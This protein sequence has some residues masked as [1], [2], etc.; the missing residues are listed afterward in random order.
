MLRVQFD[1]VSPTVRVSIAR[2]AI[3]AKKHI[4]FIL[5]AHIRYKV[6]SP[7]VAILISISIY[8]YMSSVQERMGETQVSK[9]LDVGL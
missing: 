2:I 6:N 3:N 1:S 9:G 4:K 5:L 7:Q 8:K